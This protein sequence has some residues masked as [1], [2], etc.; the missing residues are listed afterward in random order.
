M[1]AYTIAHDIFKPNLIVATIKPNILLINLICNNE[2][3]FHVEHSFGQTMTFNQFSTSPVINVCF[4]NNDSF[5]L[6]MKYH[7]I[8]MS[9]FS[10]NIC[11]LF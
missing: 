1:E 4:N 8:I 7:S 11:C 2:L 9:I 10:V 3:F 5:K 6:T